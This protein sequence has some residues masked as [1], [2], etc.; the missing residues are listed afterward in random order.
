MQLYR[1]WLHERPASAAY[2]AFGGGLTWAGPGESHRERFEHEKV[3]GY[4][5]IWVPRDEIQAFA[6]GVDS[7]SVPDEG[8]IFNPREGWVDLPSLVRD[9]LNDFI[10]AGGAIRE[11][12][13]LC[14]PAV[15]AG[16]V[17]GVHTGSR[18]LIA[19]DAVVWA[20]G[21]SVPEDLAHVGVVIPNG[22]PAAFVAFTEPVDSPL[23]VVL[24]TP[25]A[26][27][28][29]TIDGG[30][31]IDS[32]WSEEAMTVAEDGALHVPHEVVSGLLEEASR[33]LVGRPRL[34]VARI[35]A[36]FKPIP[37]DGEPVIGVVPGIDGLYTAFSHSGATL[38]LLVGKLISDEIVSGHVSDIQAPFRPRRFLG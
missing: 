23:T 2:L 10:A 32:A 19:S 21:P 34:T 30:L 22:S 20:T 4:P 15:D 35:G 27:V 1:E 38:G 18:E 17:I 12:V 26:S 6:P 16:A 31:A 37:G 3:L 29:P 11:G 28:R 7:A 5:T 9:L 24:N 33:L 36:G 13:G 8:A 14:R 25:R